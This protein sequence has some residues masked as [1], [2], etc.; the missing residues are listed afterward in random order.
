MGGGR[1]VNRENREH[2][3]G[4]T[5]KWWR[6]WQGAGARLLLSTPTAN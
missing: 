4:S 1:Q 6:Q 2:R 5:L 3:E